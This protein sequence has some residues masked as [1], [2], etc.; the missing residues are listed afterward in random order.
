MLWR[1]VT[2]C[3]E[4]SVISPA[5]R[6]S[7]WNSIPRLLSITS[8]K[9]K[10]CSGMSRVLTMDRNLIHIRWTGLLFICSSV[11][12]YWGEGGNMGPQSCFLL[13]H[14]QGW[15]HRAITG[16]QR[17]TYLTASDRQIAFGCSDMAET[18]W[19][20]IFTTFISRRVAS[21][22]Y[23]GERCTLIILLRHY[24]KVPESLWPSLVPIL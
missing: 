2:A 7:P 5:Y 10:S 18:S 21:G 14:S 1:V 8:C 3:T 22:A 16:N 20:E 24:S 17:L 19:R 11:E 15:A 9:Y 4:K 6:V 13:D 12:I 23:C